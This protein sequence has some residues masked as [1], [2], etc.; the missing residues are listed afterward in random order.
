MAPH[1][2]SAENDFL[3]DCVGEGYTPVEIHAKLAARRGKSGLAAP[4]LTNVRKALK[5][6]TYRRANVETRGRRKKLKSHHIRKLNRTRIK[7]IKATKGEREVHWNEIIA[8]ARVPKI[9]SQTASR[10]LRAIGIDVKWRAPRLK[11]MRDRNAIAER[12]EICAKWKNYAKTY[13]HE[14]L[15]LIMDNKRFEIPTRSCSLRYKRKLKV[16]GHLRTRAEGIRASFTKP[17]KKKH[18][19]NTGGA[20]NVLGGILNNQ[21]K[22]WHYLPKRWNGSVAE[23]AYQGPIARAL[24]HYRG[25]KPHY[26]V[27]EDNDPAGYKANKACDAKRGLSITTVDFPRYSPDL[28][29]MDFFV[30]SEVE[31]RMADGRVRGTE[32]VAQHKARMRRTAMSI[33]SAV[34]KKAVESIKKRAAAIYAN[35]G[36]DIP[37]D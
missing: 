32:T 14:H 2:T 15:D 24:K 20:C 25:V 7:I 1:L 10:S 17:D 12:M 6:I 16:R 28:N 5:G 34:I 8:K 29:P 19:L 23:C 37:R 30:R 4:H 11:P 27:L 9:S 13:F 36:G 18:R 33:P 21:I 35:A 3:R 26:K 31:R 22:L